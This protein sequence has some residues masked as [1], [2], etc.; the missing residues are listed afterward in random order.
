MA[1]R[2]S[3]LLIIGLS[4]S[5]AALLFL[6]I[7]FST[8]HWLELDTKFITNSGFEK[9]G[10]WEA[11][12][13]N[14]AF[15][16]DYTGKLYNGCWWI[17]SYEYRPIWSFINPRKLF[18]FKYR[19]YRGIIVC[20]LNFLFSPVILPGQ[21]FTSGIF[22]NCLFL[23]FFS[24]VWKYIN[25]YSYNNW[26]SLKVLILYVYIAQNAHVPPDIQCVQVNSEINPTMATLKDL[27]TVEQNS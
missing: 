24:C 16:R 11:C 27:V 21:L 25:A 14:F 8:P 20:I 2:G 17:F 19:I 26:N 1:D 9:I 3:L 23:W 15:Y 13:K 6:V 10:L 4:F 7:G 12:F 18:L 22:W 5:G